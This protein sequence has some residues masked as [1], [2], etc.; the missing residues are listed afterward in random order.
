MLAV[1]P[2]ST[3]ARAI[4]RASTPPD[5]RTASTEG[6]RSG[7]QDPPAVQPGAD[8]GTRAPSW[9][10]ALATYPACGPVPHGTISLPRRQPPRRVLTCRLD[11]GVILR[12]VEWSTR[13]HHEVMQAPRRRRTPATT[14]PGSVGPAVRRM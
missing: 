8:E 9:S 13:V 3:A 4:S 5:R 11:G 14:C 10:A 12:P 2:D 1:H 6:V 7:T